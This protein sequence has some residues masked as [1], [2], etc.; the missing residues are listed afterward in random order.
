[1][2][3]AASHAR[4]RP[5]ART[6]AA[7]LPRTKTAARSPPGSAW[8]RS[9]RSRPDWRGIARP[10]PRRAATDDAGPQTARSGAPTDRLAHQREQLRPRPPRH[11]LPYL[12]RPNSYSPG[13]RTYHH[14]TALPPRPTC[15]LSPFPFPVSRLPPPHPRTRQRKPVVVRQPAH[16]YHRRRHLRQRPGISLPDRVEHQRRRLLLDQTLELT[17]E[18]LHRHVGG[19]GEARQLVRVVEVVAPQPN[20]VTA[21][22]GVARRRDVHPPRARPARLRIDHRPKRD[23][24]EAPPLQ[25]NHGG[26]A[27]PQ[28]VLGGAIAQVA[29]V[30]H[31]HGDRVRAAQLVPDVLRRDGR[32]QPELLQALLHRRLEDLADVHLGD[33]DVPVRIP[34]D[35]LE[36]R[37]VRGF[38]ADHQ[39]LGDHRDAVEPAVGQPLDD[40]THQRVHDRLE[41]DAPP[42]K[43]LRDE[44]E[45]GP[46]GLADAH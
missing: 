38:D 37:E 9:P 17:A 10:R 20:H 35:L 18:L 30:L 28:H 32:L 33:A 23:G 46:R 11:Q 22:D 7:T 39:T 14:S 42:Q 15:P 43:L 45:R 34:L 1:P 29:R 8:S 5:D 21:R 36:A 4:S 3:L 13:A 6:V 16:L 44:R 27:T 2:A 25:R 24:N 26:V 41:P 40:R 19:R 12:P 31:V